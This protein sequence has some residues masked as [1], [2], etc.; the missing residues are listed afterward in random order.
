MIKQEQKL[1]E[2]IE[3]WDNSEKAQ[4]IRLLKK[5]M[6]ETSSSNKTQPSVVQ[7]YVKKAIEAGFNDQSIPDYPEDFTLTAKST[8]YKEIIREVVKELGDEFSVKQTGNVVLKAAWEEVEKSRTLIEF[9]K[10]FKL[11]L[12]AFRAKLYTEEDLEEYTTML[13][14]LDR[15]VRQ[16]REYKRIYEEMFGVLTSDDENVGTVLRANCR[17]ATQAEQRPSGTISTTR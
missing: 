1:E 13:N 16:L 8:Y 6:S 11:Y 15:E 9:R 14:E 7:D 4:A 2:L 12:V 5:S 17:L 3:A 10:A